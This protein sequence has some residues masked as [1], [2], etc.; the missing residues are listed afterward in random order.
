[1][2]F[3]KKL[4]YDDIRTVAFGSITG[5]FTTLGSAFTRPARLIKIVNTTNQTAEITTDGTNVEDIVPS[6][7]FTLYDLTT[8][9]VNDEGAFFASGT[10]FSVRRPAAE[11]N[12]ISGSVYLIMIGGEI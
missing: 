10:Q 2:G 1:M 6:N 9:R 12:P 8:N 7:S 3:P 11:V 5:T 4:T